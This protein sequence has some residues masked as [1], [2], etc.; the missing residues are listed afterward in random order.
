MFPYGPFGASLTCVGISASCYGT[1]TRGSE[2]MLEG[3]NVILQQALTDGQSA[4]LNVAMFQNDN[5]FSASV[6]D[7]AAAFVALTDNCWPCIAIHPWV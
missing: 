4:P 1:F 5:S 7:G 6:C 3:L 2:Y